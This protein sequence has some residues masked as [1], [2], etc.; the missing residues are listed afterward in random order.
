[1]KPFVRSAYNYDMAAASRQLGT[2]NDAPSLTVQS[3][4]DDADIN[5]LVRRFGVTGLVRMHQRP[6]LPEQFADVF[7]FQSAMNLI[8]ESQEAFADLPATVR[9]R[10]NNNPAA[11][12]DFC[13]NPD[14]IEDMRKMGLAHPAKVPDPE[15]EPQKVQIVNPPVPD[16]PA[17][18]ST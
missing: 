3:D 4:K 1:M 6:P 16:P 18:G 17:K 9:D 10:F 15:P 14:N 11:F 13:G 5:V 12:V 2:R 8:R 7:D